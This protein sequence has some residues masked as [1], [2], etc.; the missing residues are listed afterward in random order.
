MKMRLKPD[1]VAQLCNFHSLQ[2]EHSFLNMV[3]YVSLVSTNE[4]SPCFKFIEYLLLFFYV[5][6]IVEHLT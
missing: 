2:S 5:T 3:G 6:L 1:R 4:V